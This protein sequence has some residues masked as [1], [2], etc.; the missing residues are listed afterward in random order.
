MDTAQSFADLIESIL[1]SAAIVI[2]GVWGY[3]LFRRHRRASFRADLDLQLTHVLFPDGRRLLHLALGILNK[4][5]VLLRVGY[6]E[7][8]VRQVLPVPADLVPK[9]ED[10][11]DPVPK[12]ET[13]LSWPA[14]V[15]REWNLERGAV[16]IEPGESDSLHA[17]CVIKDDVSVIQLYAFVQNPRKA[18]RSMGWTT[19]T[20]HTFDVGAK[21]M[22]AKD[23]NRQTREAGELEERQQKQ[24]ARQP[25]QQSQ[26]QK[27]NKK[28]DE[29]RTSSGKN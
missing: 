19:T 2:A 6:A 15:V 21:M 18:Q 10:D 12:G 24:Q 23:K 11:V 29:K 27:P 17:D 9:S 7:I 8:R 1:T 28:E 5:A 16:E 22:D 14:I 13:E 25:S 26:Q 3:F 4:G 20:L